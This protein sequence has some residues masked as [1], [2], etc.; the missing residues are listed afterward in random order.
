MMAAVAAVSLIA[1]SCGGGSQCSSDEKGCCQGDAKSE[2]VVSSAAYDVDD[3]LAIADSLAGQE[4]EIE[5]VCTHLCMHGATKLFL[6][7][8]NGS[9]RV[10]AGEL[11]SFS[12][13]CVNSV[14]KITGVVTEDRID[15]AYLQQWEAQLEANVAETHGDGEQAGCAAEKGARKEVGN[16]V[17]ERIASFR[18]RIA[19]REAKDGKA[20]LSFYHVLATSYEIE[21]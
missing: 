17:Q 18:A 8:E 7:G 15:E 9:L 12:K 16:T 4:V 11:G 5:G 10:E 20:Y 19:E 14:V 2:A 13:D 21:Q 3:L 6:M 1:F